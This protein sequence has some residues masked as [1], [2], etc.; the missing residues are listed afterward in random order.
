MRHQRKRR[1][2]GVKSKHRKAMMRNLLRNLVIYKRIRTTVTRA[3]DARSFIEH[4]LHLAKQSGLHTRRLLISKLGDAEI[5]DKLMKEIAPHFMKRQGGYTRIVRLG[6]RPGDAADMALLEFTE[7]LDAPKKEK[8]PK[9]A[10]KETK[11]EVKAEEAPAKKAKETPAESKP[12][13]SEKKA[14]PESEE[15]DKSEKK[16]AEK[17]GGFLGTLRKFLKGDE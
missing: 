6:Y 1:K 11:A 12:K 5:V 13:A 16:E 15:T 8:K 9:K 7:V 3:K 10:K 4:M 2:L 14:K 17:K